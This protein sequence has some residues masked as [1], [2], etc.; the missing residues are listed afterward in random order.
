MWLVHKNV[1]NRLIL[2]AILLCIHEMSG[3]NYFT[4]MKIKAKICFE[5]SNNKNSMV[6]VGSGVANRGWAGSIFCPGRPGKEGRRDWMWLTMVCIAGVLCTCQENCRELEASGCESQL[7]HPEIQALQVFNYY[8]NGLTIYFF[9]WKFF[10]SPFHYLCVCVS[11]VFTHWYKNCLWI[12]N[13]L[14]IKIYL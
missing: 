7:S 6:I 13:F 11:C 2:S 9:F 3:Y 10:F 5:F 14:Y 8:V 1:N 12:A 4:M